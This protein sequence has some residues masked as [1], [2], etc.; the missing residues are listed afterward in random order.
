MIG[1]GS[2]MPAR[3]SAGAARLHTFRRTAHTP[4]RSASRLTAVDALRGAVMVIM[5]LDHTR[6]F[7][8]AGAMSFSPEDLAR[9]TPAVFLTRWVTHICAPVFVLLAGVGAWCRM[10]RDGSKP[11]LS[12][13]LWTRGLWLIVIEITVMR[14]ALNFSLSSEFPILLLVLWALGLSMIALAALIHLPRPWLAALSVAVIVLHNTLDGIQA[15]QLGALAPL[16]IVLHQQGVVPLAGLIVFV[17]YPVLPW[18]AVM[19]AGFCSGSVLSMEPARRRW[20]MTT[21]GISLVVLFVALRALNV[22]GNPVPWS[23]QPSAVFTVL[24]FLNTT[25]Y[26]PSL[27]FLAMTLGPALLA[28]AWLDRRSLAPDHPL[29]VIGRVPFFFYVVHFYALHLWCVVMAWW[30]YGGAASSFVLN[31]VPSMGGPRASFPPDF[32]YPLWVVYVVWAGIVLALYPLCRWF[33]RMKRQRQAWWLS[34][35]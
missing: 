27:A 11:A 35:V 22:Y 3:D 32:G 12:R 13:F 23:A 2:A 30:R 18:I 4:E 26:P 1:G 8:H 24:S 5:A 21:A 20:W 28:L 9:T 25:K 14:L 19:A 34:Y 17:A 10:R 15:S 6:D 29:A 16:W 33:A 7:F 31:P